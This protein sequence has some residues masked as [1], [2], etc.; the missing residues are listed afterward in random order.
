MSAKKL[1][2]VN[3]NSSSDD[4]TDYDEKRNVKIKEND[5]E[6]KGRNS[7][8][9]SVNESEIKSNENNNDSDNNDINESNE[10]EDSHNSYKNSNNKKEMKKQ[11]IEQISP[12]CRN[13]TK[14]EFAGQTN[15]KKV[16]VKNN[17]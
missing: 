2:A 12:Y 15:T 10:N 16:K 17:A 8:N 5:A 6:N 4:K 13:L 3:S 7:G 1:T 14:T 11:H 9:Y